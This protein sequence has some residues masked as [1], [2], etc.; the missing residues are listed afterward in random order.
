MLKPILFIFIFYFGLFIISNAQV[1][2]LTEKEKDAIY[3]SNSW[4]DFWKKFE[5]KHQFIQIGA[6]YS[7]ESTSLKKYQSP[8]LYDSKNEKAFPIGFKFGARIDFQYKKKTN[9]SSNIYLNYLSS[10]IQESTTIDLPPL[11]D[12]FYAYPTKNPTWYLGLQLL[13]KKSILKSKNNITTINWIIGPGFDLQISPQNIDQKQYKRANY[14]LLSGITGF[15]LTN[16]KRQSIGFQYQY[17][18]NALNSIIE[19]KF[20]SW[21]CILSIPIQ[22]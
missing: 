16:L 9:W 5:L 17:G 8:F 11:I 2:I 12:Q 6:Q 21:Q 13:Y 19:S 1:K 20:S 15:E 14:Y 3:L 22:N 7:T 18:I 10:S 4:K